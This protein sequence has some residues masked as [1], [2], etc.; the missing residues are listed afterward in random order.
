MTKFVA[1]ENE[2]VDPI[3]KLT[4]SDIEKMVE[5]VVVPIESVIKN[6]G[7][8]IMMNFPYKKG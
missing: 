4:E 2:K 8:V 6:A 1:K 7:E 5:S 3:S